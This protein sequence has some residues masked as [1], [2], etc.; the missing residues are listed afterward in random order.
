MRLCARADSKWRSR[1]LEENMDVAR[2]APDNLLQ[3]PTEMLLKILSWLGPQDLFKCLR[4]FAGTA[5]ADL[6]FD[7]ILIREMGTIDIHELYALYLGSSTREEMRWCTHPFVRARTTTLTL[8]DVLELEE[9]SKEDQR[10][11]FF[12]GLDF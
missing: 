8:T 10:F 1:N 12:D 6:C 11:S 9:K 7:K 2:S 4:S 5:I 3:L